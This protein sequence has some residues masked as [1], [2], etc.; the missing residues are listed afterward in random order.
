MG[1][2]GSIT[3]Q[4][5]LIQ[6]YKSLGLDIPILHAHF[7]QNLD[8]WESEL[9]L[10]AKSG[11]RTGSAFRHLGR[12]REVQRQIAERQGECWNIV[13]LVRDPI[14]RNLSHFFHALPQSVPDWETLYAAGNLTVEELQAMFI[15]D[16]EHHKGPAV[17]FENELKRSFGIDV[18]RTPF[19][20][21]E[22]YLIYP[23][24][25]AARLLVVRLEDLDRVA[26]RAI[27][28]FLGL[29]GFQ[30]Q[31][32]NVAGDREYFE[33]YDQV[34][35]LPLPEEFVAEMYA[36]QYARHFYSDAEIQAFTRR[37]TRR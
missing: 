11:Y 25:P 2:V 19:P 33:L 16:I 9:I 26:E 10:R 22:G 6:S 12:S 27:H 31:M 13:T 17:W 28:E 21:S 34:K 18:Y 14:A 35:R 4:K 20:C 24:A 1:K 32:L 36:T 23:P 37:W 7:L 30:M 5:A 3:V 29:D 8:K 15:A